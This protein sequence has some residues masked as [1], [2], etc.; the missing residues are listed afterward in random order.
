MLIQ[1]IKHCDICG[2]RI[3]WD[4]HKKPAA[5]VDH[6]HDSNVVRGVLCQ[7]CNVG[8]G[9]LGDTVEG[10]KIALKYLE[11]SPGVHGERKRKS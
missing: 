4:V 1:K 6:C 3:H 8:L 11:Q 5:Q 7:E 2:K 9:K 10:L